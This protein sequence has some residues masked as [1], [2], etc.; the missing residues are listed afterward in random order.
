MLCTLVLALL[1]CCCTIEHQTCLL[2]VDED[3]AI[4]V[5][6]QFCQIEMMCYS[7]ELTKRLI[8][9]SQRPE[10]DMGLQA[11]QLQQVAHAV[12]AALNSKLKAP[13]QRK[14]PTAAD[15]LGSQGALECQVQ[16][17]F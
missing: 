14:R 3:L 11:E 7:Q 15:T 6:R 16:R 10:T 5:A 9:L 17:S 13:E 8:I 2:R 1:V 12:Q 4:H